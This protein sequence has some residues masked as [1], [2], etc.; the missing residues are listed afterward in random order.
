MRTFLSKSKYLAGLQCPK[1]LWT[2]VYEPEKI[3]PPDTATQYLFDNGHAVGKLAWKLYPDGINIPTDDFRANLVKSRQSLGLRKP[4]FEPAIS[5]DGLYSRVDILNP[6]GTDSWD[7]IEVKSSTILKDVNIHDISFQKY[8]CG[9]AGLEIDRCWLA[10]VN[11]KYVRDREI[12]AAGFFC[13]DDVTELVSMVMGGVEDR[14]QGMLEVLADGQCPEV[15]IGKHCFS[16][17]ECAL[18]PVC[19]EALPE[20]SVFDLRGGKSN[21]LALYRQGIVLIADIPGEA[22][23][24]RQQKIQKECILNGC[25]HVE[26]GP[27]R[28][29]LDSVAYPCYFLDF[30]TIGPVV[31]IYDGMRPYQTIPFQFSLHVVE[32]DGSEAVHHEYLANGE[33]DPRHELLS[34]LYRLLGESG[35]IVAYNAG[36]EIGVLKEL[37]A[38]YPEYEGWLEGILARVVDLL[39]PFTNFH[40]YNPSQKET[41]SLKKVL[42]AITG[43]GYKELGIGAGMDASIA[44][45][46]V[47]YGQATREEKERVRADLLKYCKLDTEGMIWIME[48]LRELAG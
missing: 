38:L 12:D 32:Q 14:I 21:Q 3:A 6:V 33:A 48:K 7:I 34:E 42:P 4:L 41:A 15:D 43:I 30:E 22:K 35:S 16:P 47:T 37:V 10:Y 46:R 20:N 31:P 24:S 25:C 29:F 26:K 1:L 5:V 44:Y 17:Y 19:F 8:C 13:I 45:E 9:Q 36:F 11:N 27:I 2:Q 23:L 39:Y 28:Q 40:Y 18:R